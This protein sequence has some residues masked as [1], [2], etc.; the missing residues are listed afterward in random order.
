MVVHVQ[1][2][3]DDVEDAPV[4]VD[5]ERAAPDLEHRKSALHAEEPR[6][7]AVL[8]T[9]QREAQTIRFVE[10]TLRQDRVEGDTETLCAQC[11]EVGRSITEVARLARASRG[12]S[13]WIEEEDDGP[14]HEELGQ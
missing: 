5:H 8:V 13:R 2:A 12:E 3:G 4:L 11:V 1:L 14:A 7:V 9:E 10:A 6:D